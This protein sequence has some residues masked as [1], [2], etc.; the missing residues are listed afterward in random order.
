MSRPFEDSSF[1]Q[2]MASEARIRE[3]IEQALT[4]HHALGTTSTSPASSPKEAKVNSPELF[5]GDRTKTRNFLVQ[6][7]VVFRIQASRFPNDETKVYF[8]GSFLRGPAA[9]WFS[10]FVEKQDPILKDWNAFLQ[11]FK[12]TFEHPD[13]PAEAAR[14]LRNLRQG[15][16]S[17]ALLAAD[18]RRIAVDVDWTI[19]SLIDAFYDALND[20]VKDRIIELERP[21]TLEEYI[22][23]AIKIDDRQVQ[24]LN[25]KNHSSTLKSTPPKKTQSTNNSSQSP[26]TPGFRYATS[27]D[28]GP[29][30]MQLDAGQQ[31]LTE[32]EK[33][34]RRSQGLCL[35][36]GQSGHIARVCPE[37]RHPRGSGNSANVST[38]QGNMFASQSSRNPKLLVSIA[39]FEPELEPLFTLPLAFTL[40]NG[41]TGTFAAML[42][43]GASSNFITQEVVDQFDLPVVIKKHPIEL[44]VIDGSPAPQGPI[45]LETCSIKISIGNHQ[46]SLVFDV[47]PSSHYQAI[48]GLPWLSK[49]NPSINWT[50]GTLVFSDSFCKKECLSIAKQINATQVTVP[51]APALEKIQNSK[52][53]QEYSA[54]ADVFEKQ[55]ADLFPEHRKYDI[56]IDL[57]PGNSPPWG[58]I[59]S[60]STP[61]LE[62]LKSYIDENLAKGFIRHSKSPAGAPVFFMTKKDKTCC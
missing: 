28:S 51:S 6:V 55:N 9:S 49:H 37:K 57:I 52:L 48:L 42:D 58:P 17:A 47:L 41:K 22:E 12:Q 21:R 15:N 24:R 35:Y 45:K 4:G 61:E 10:P 62:T 7:T 32:E 43:S 3:L 19:S 36:C 44:A 40:E 39:G 14:Q 23:L 31:K 50:Q 11:Q 26:T 46:E 60:L 34:R 27:N 20:R 1:D 8:L 54:F 13:R 59:Y 38:K 2:I 5:S 18:F 16:K 25:E 30:P 29:V 33:N 56:S 53:P